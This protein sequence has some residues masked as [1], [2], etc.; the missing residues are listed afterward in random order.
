[1]IK[2]YPL[3]SVIV[4]IY[5]SEKYLN[6][7]IRSILTQTYENFELILINDGSTDKSSQICDYFKN[8]DKR[9]KVINQHNKG[10]S[11]AR[12][13]G[14]KISEGEYISFVD[15]DDY[16]EKDY[17]EYLFYLIKK[18]DSDMS[19]CNTRDEYINGNFID[20]SCEEECKLYPEGAL[21]I[22]LYQKGFDVGPWAKLYKKNLFE[23][24]KFPENKI[25]E[26]FYVSYRIVHKCNK[27]A[28]GKQAKYHYLHHIN[29]TMTSMFSKKNLD[30]I[31][32]SEDM[33]QF[34]S[35]KYPQIINAA[36]R[37]FV[38]S[39]HHLL[40]LM[41]GS[42]NYSEEIEKKLIKNIKQNARTVLKDKKSSFKDKAAVICLYMGKLFYKNC[43]KIMKKATNNY[44]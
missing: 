38:Y 20:K 24:I 2:V 34:V 27:V 28:Y 11:I 3:I 37:R 36:V 33:L 8:K 19:V 10:Q 14:I 43:F 35:N 17:L 6:K 1:M 18:F 25:Y 7:C 21:E 32:V 31:E 13:L 4:P 30:L 26:D 29:S 15:A 5:N 40:N 16:I 42:K 22:M 9:I 23:K 41:Y 12:N 39:N 44:L